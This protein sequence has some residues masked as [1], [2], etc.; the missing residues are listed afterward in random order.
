MCVATVPRYSLTLRSAGKHLV[1]MMPVVVIMVAAQPIVVAR[2]TS[3]MDALYRL[4]TRCASPAIDQSSAEP[5]AIPDRVGTRAVGNP[6]I[7]TAD[8]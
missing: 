4:L 3:L 8:G 1:I 7:L 2:K 6:R 5:H